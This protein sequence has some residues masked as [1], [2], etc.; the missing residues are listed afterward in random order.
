MKGPLTEEFMKMKYLYLLGS[1]WPEEKTQP[2][3]PQS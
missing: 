2:M 1:A 3:V